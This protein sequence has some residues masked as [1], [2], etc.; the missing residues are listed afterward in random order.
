MSGG[1]CAGYFLD[2]VASGEIKSFTDVFVGA[3][4]ESMKL[5]AAELATQADIYF[6]A[7]IQGEKNTE[8]DFD[9]F[10]EAWLKGGGRQ[11]TEEADAWYKSVQD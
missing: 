11:M 9:A 2:R 1:Q 7:V 3:P 10:V 6:N 5:Y 4:T 8:E